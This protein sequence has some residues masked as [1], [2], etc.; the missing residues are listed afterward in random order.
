MSKIKIKREAKISY[1]PSQAADSLWNRLSNKKA[2][3]GKDIQKMLDIEDEG[4][5]ELGGAKMSMMDVLAS[6]GDTSMYEEDD[7]QDE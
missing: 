6:I 7:E 5:P 4:H 3:K 2:M 1:D